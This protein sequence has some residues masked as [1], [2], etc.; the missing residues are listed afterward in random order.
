MVYVFREN[1][2]VLLCIHEV[3]VNAVNPATIFRKTK[4][5]LLFTSDDF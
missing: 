5:F 1:H 2:C 3:L 4:T